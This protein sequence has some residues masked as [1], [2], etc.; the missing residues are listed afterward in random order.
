MTSAVRDIPSALAA[1]RKLY[2]SVRSRVAVGGTI[3]AICCTSRINRHAFTTVVRDTLGNQFS[4][5]LEIPAEPDHPAAFAEADYL[6]VSLWKRR[7]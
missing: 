6:K 4:H 2:R 5:S 7:E 3:A 1:Y